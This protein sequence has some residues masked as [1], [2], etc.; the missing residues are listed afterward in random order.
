MKRTDRRRKYYA[1][2]RK[3]TAQ[4]APRKRLGHTVDHIVPVSWGFK[5][6]LPPERIGSAANLNVVPWTEN[7]AKAAQI[8]PEMIDLLRA[9]EYH[10]LAHECQQRLG[11]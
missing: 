5:H 9:W 3:I 4:N 8:T 7:V 11:R 6:D 1:D 10:D 2:V